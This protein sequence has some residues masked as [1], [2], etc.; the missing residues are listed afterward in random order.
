MKKRLLAVAAIALVAV[1]SLS[2]CALYGNDRSHTSLMEVTQDGQQIVFRLLDE[3]LLYDPST[4]TLSKEEA[5]WDYGPETVLKGDTFPRGTLEA[6]EG[7]EPLCEQVKALALNPEDPLIHALAWEQ[8][9][10]VY[11]FCNVYSKATGFLSGGGQCDTKHIVRAVLFT[12]ENETLTIKEEIASSVVV[13]YDGTHVIFFHDREY[14]SKSEGGEP[15]FICDDVAFDT[16]MTSYGYA[17]FYFGGGYCVLFFNYDKGN[18]KK[19]YHLYVLATMA[20]EKLAELRIKN[21][22][23]L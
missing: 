7:Y 4:Q 19:Q 3:R 21:P 23:D 16:G 8:N 13:A 6:K 12:Y 17:R 11:G 15:K 2:G 10:T 18:A 5:E 22:Y 1:I 14:F 9:G 20:G